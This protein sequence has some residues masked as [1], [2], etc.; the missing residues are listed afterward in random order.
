MANILGSLIEHVL[1]M[2]GSWGRCGQ[3]HGTVVTWTQPSSGSPL[4]ITCTTSSA[5]LICVLLQVPTAP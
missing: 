5:Q 4:K 2:T 1:A 3:G